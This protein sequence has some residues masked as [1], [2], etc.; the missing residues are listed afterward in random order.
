[1]WRLEFNYSDWYHL[2]M[3]ADSDITVTVVC[4][5]DLMVEVILYKGTTQEDRDYS[6][7]RGDNCYISYSGTASDYYYLLIR[8]IGDYGTM[9]YTGDYYDITINIDSG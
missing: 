8:L 5:A 1:M 6:V 4:D 7:S 2:D 9:G 3:E